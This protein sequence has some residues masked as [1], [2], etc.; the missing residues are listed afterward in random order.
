[1]ACGTNN[2]KKAEA[3][4]KR[5]NDPNARSGPCGG[6]RGLTPL[7]LAA[8]FGNTKLIQL[9]LDHGADPKLLNSKGRSAINFLT[10]HNH[11]TKPGLLKLLLDAGCPAASSCLVWPVARGNLDAVRQLI[12][13][14][15]NVNAKSDGS[16]DSPPLGGG[17]SLVAIAVNEIVLDR[18]MSEAMRRIKGVV[19]P[20]RRQLYLDILRQLIKAG[21]DV[22][23]PG[24][25][26]RYP[27]W[28]AAH[29]GDMEVVKLLLEA[30]A[31]PNAQVPE[32]WFGT[33]LHGAAQEGHLEAARLLLEAG[34]AP[35]A[36]GHN[37]QKPGDRTR[38]AKMRELLQSFQ[39]KR[40][41]RPSTVTK[42]P[43]PTKPKPPP[44]PRSKQP[45]GAKSFLQFLYQGHPQWALAAVHAPL[46]AVVKALGRHRKIREIARNVALKPLTTRLG[47]QLDA[48]PVVRIQN[49]PWTLVLHALFTPE[50]ESLGQATTDAPALS[51]QL[52]THAV[53]FVGQESASMM[54]LQL[55]D[56][57]VCIET[58]VWDDSGEVFKFESKLRTR[59]KLPKD[60]F[61]VAE[62]LFSESGIRLIPCFA[63]GDDKHTWAAVEKGLAPLIQRVDVLTM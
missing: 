7:M 36:P 60:G 56:R 11:E 9:L 40:R 37:G 4:L 28:N 33:P 24:P 31:D 47:S 29:S 50:C 44:R 63:I 52:S 22:N 45:S 5:G 35:G 21:A 25:V 2:R 53:S 26:S 23:V 43:K 10:A 39:G 8:G 46:D 18:I 61:D 42:P 16:F 12:A 13:A 3:L 51:K 20:K 57:G 54:E 32:T 41:N 59:P 17:A 19:D 30:G 38:S 15:A 62:Q 58:V 27:L 55:F 6:E 49:N 48:V 1:L 14:G 34:A